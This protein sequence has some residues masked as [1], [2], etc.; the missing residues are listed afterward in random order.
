V[1]A[2]LLLFAAFSAKSSK[3]VDKY[4]IGAVL[5]HLLLAQKAAKRWTSTRLG[6]S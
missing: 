6:L 2:Y 5:G 3:K 4:N 1:S